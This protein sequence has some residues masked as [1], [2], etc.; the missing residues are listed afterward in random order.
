MEVRAGEKTI[1]V[2]INGCNCCLSPS[3]LERRSLRGVHSR[4]MCLQ[5]ETPNTCLVAAGIA[6]DLHV[7]RCFNLLEST[8]EVNVTQVAFALFCAL[9]FYSFEYLFRFFES[10]SLRHREQTL[11]EA[12]LT[13]SMKRAGTSERLVSQPS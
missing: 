9:R 4:V 8:S 10:M 2:S 7:I 1:H 13:V 3:L 12:N 11:L 5:T 6:L